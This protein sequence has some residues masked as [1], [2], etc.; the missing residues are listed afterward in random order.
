M[1]MRHTNWLIDLQRHEKPPGFDNDPRTQM[2]STNLFQPRSFSD[3]PN[4]PSMWIG[5]FCVG[6]AFS[7]R[8]ARSTTS[9][10]DLEEE[11][12]KARRARTARHRET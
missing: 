5:P 8:G 2:A 3:R 6:G 7:A 1:K 12:E 11:S 9:R 4:S 10:P